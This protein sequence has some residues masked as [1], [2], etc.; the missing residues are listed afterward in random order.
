MATSAFDNGYQVRYNPLGHYTLSVGAGVET[1]P[2]PSVDPERVRRIV[3]RL[4][5]GSVVFTDDGQAPIPGSGGLGL[6]ILEGEILVYDGMFP[7]NLQLTRDGGAD[8][9]VRVA[10]Y[11]T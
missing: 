7:E 8:A 9:D 2:P 11:G 4:V 3:I 5:S 6:P 1:L 10:Y